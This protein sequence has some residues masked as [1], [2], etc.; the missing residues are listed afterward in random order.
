MFPK[1]RSALT[2]F[3]GR[4]T[5]STRGTRISRS[6]MN[7]PPTPTRPACQVFDHEV[8]VRPSDVDSAHHLNHVAIVG[9]FEYGRVR[10]H[11]DLRRARPDL[12]D[13]ST[14]VRRVTIEYLAQAAM[15][16]VLSVRSWIRR[17]GRTSRTWAQEVVR[18]D[19]VLVARAEVTSVLLDRRTGRPAELPMI[20][21]E[22]FDPY[23][24]AETH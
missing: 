9:F 1:N 19:G 23:R 15:F 13:M 14:V 16:D 3:R 21:R 24:E 6:D 11:H 12:P 8:V 10:A 4:D 20:Y 18:P 22:I 7:A 5:G 2:S 17:D